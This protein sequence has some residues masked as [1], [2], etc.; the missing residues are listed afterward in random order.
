MSGSPSS[1]NTG[2]LRNPA[3]FHIR[4]LLDVEV[5]AEKEQRPEKDRESSREQRFRRLDVRE[6]VV[7]RSDEDP[8]HEVDEPAEA[9][10]DLD[11]P[12]RHECQRGDDERD[13]E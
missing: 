10:P 4:P 6:V 2:S 5:D 9:D 12:A 13:D 11:P 7:R 3:D 1:S 8:D